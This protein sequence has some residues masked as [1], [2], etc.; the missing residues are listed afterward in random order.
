MIWGGYSWTNVN[1]NVGASVDVLNLNAEW[2]K[3]V[4]DTTNYNVAYD[5]IEYDYANDM[6]IRRFEK[7]SNVD[8]KCNK[9]QYDWFAV[10]KGFVHHSI[11]V[12]QFGNPFNIL[13][14]KGQLNVDVNNGYNECINFSGAHQ[15]LLTLGSTAYQSSISFGSGARQFS[16][17][18]GSGAYQSNISFGTNAYQGNLTFGS[19]A[20]QNS[21]TFG[22]NANQQNLNFGSNARQSNLTFGTNEI[23]RAH[24]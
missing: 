12:Q 1:G 21:L 2:T 23:G 14:V 10:A 7:E 8:V 4:Y 24:V 17:S 18:F 11:S 16:I 19:G 13:T 15:V 9:A 3:N 5:L 6:I 20:Y 22:S